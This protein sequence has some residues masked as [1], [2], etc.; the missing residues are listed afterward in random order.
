VSAALCVKFEL[1]RR[2]MITPNGLAEEM[3][4]L[5]R[6]GAG[7]ALR[8]VNPTIRG[9]SEAVGDGVSVFESEAGKMN[10]GRSVRRVVMIFVRIEQQVGRIHDPNAV[11]IS[12]RAGGDVYAGDE[13]FVR[14]VITV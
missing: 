12:E 14:L 1:M 6:R 10:L 13:I 5:H 8:A 11:A 9:P 3:N 4:A 2:W 7:A